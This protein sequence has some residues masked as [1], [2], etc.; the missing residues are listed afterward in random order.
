MQVLIGKIVRSRGLKGEVK[1]QILTNRPEVFNTANQIYI[2]KKTFN[3]LKGSV[4]NGSG[5]MYLEGIDH[6]DKAEQLRGKEI[7]IDSKDLN[8]TDDE[9]LSTDLIGFDVIHKNK[10]IGRIKSIE[11]FGGGDF[12]EIAV[13]G[14]GF[15][16]IPNEDDFIEETNMTNKTLTLKDN[17]LDVEEVL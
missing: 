6:I 5:F 4:Q 12:F 9:V 3:V 11:N 13:T 10:K 8:L 7:F 17:A 2:D 16:Q 14:T 1:I 15:V